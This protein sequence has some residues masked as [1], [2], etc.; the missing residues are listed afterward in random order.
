ME[1]GSRAA[2]S[3]TPECGREAEPRNRP[4]GSA[5]RAARAGRWER[6]WTVRPRGPVG[7][8]TTLM[9]CSILIIKVTN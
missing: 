2:G 7:Q 3:R 4:P 5:R 6:S 9:V 8:N 1:V